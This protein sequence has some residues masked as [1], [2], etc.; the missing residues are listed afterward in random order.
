MDVQCC[1]NYILQEMFAHA[2][3]E[4]W[5]WNC[6]GLFS[7]GECSL[8]GM[9]TKMTQVV[10]QEEPL[11]WPLQWQNLFNSWSGEV[12]PLRSWNPDPFRWA[13]FLSV[14]AVAQWLVKMTL[15][16]LSP[17]ASAHL[18]SPCVILTAKR[19]A[20]VGTMP[21]LWSQVALPVLAVL[22]NHVTSRAISSH[23]IKLR[24]LWWGLSDNKN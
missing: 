1:I 23:L 17:D 13:W 24:G 5:Q 16:F 15:R 14:A 8:E 22:P 6:F 4:C 10:Q 12:A 11:F 18:F 9:N 19:G 21:C 20:V 3:S 2:W 7:V